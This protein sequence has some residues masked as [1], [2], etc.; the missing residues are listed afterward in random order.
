MNGFNPI[1]YGRLP[2]EKIIEDYKL[3]G[4]IF[5]KKVPFA[6]DNGGNV[7]FICEDGKIYIIEAEFLNDKNFILVSESFTDFINSFY[8]E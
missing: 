1:K 6:Y 3:S 5:E 7:F 2:I 8:N 4:I